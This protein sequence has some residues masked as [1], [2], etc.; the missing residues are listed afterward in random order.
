MHETDIIQGKSIVSEEKISAKLMID[1]LESNIKSSD[2]DIQ[3]IDNP[4]I[5]K[6]KDFISDDEVEQICQSI[7]EMN[8]IE[9]TKT[10]NDMKNQKQMFEYYKSFAKSIKDVELSEFG[11]SIDQANF[12]KLT[13]MKK[14]IDEFLASYD[15]IV[16]RIDKIIECAENRVKEFD[17]I[18][19]TTSYMNDAMLS[20]IDKKLNLVEKRNIAKNHPISIYY[21]T[22]K[23]IFTNR[24]KV[25]YILNKIPH[26][27]PNLERI[28]REVKDKQRGPANL[29]N[30][31]VFITNTLQNGFKYEQVTAFTEYI[32]KLYGNRDAAFYTMYALATI[33]SNAV[34]F[35]KTG[36]HKW[37]EVLIM[38]VLD[39]ITGSYD[40][41]GGKEVVN[42]SL[43]KIKE[44]IGY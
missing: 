5:S 38:N 25:D 20:I 18:D 34:R 9:A 42:D 33:Y 10:V 1:E 31:K 17:D 24:T 41:D 11:K 4:A 16:S 26:I 14:D 39:I 6:F 2:D 22:L 37:V 8:I 28:K 40:L 15:D 29:E 21:R 36:E 12:E 13:G 44:A 30:A 43:L 27:K 3:D 35:K 32:L 19:K 7:S 23:D